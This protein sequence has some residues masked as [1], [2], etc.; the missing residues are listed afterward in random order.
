VIVVTILHRTFLLATLSLFAAIP[1]WCAPTWTQPTPEQLKMTSDPA[2]PD[3]PAVYLFHEETVDDNV[4]F[5]RV[6]A[7]IKILT[8]KGKEDF[9][10]IEIP[11]EGGGS[12]IKAVEGR[13]IHADGTVIPFTGKPYSKE[14]VKSGDVKWMAKVF[15]MPDV[16]VGS[17]IEYR[18]ELQYSDDWYM[19]PRFYLQESAFTHK[20]HYHFVPLNLA[21]TTRILTGKD[22]FGKE[23]VANRLLYYSNLPPGVKVRAGM[24][25]YDLVVENVPA[26]TEEEFSPPLDSYAYQ[27]LF[28]YSQASSGVDFWKEEGKVWSKDVDRFANPSDKI[29]Q[30]VAGIVGVGD[31]DDQKLR[32]IY[33]AVMTVENTRLTRE[34][35]AEENKA[36]GLRVKTAADIWEQK[37]GSD[38][39]ITRLFIAMARA[40]GLKA[41]AMAVPER[42]K[43]LFN[44][45]WL[46]WSQL[47]DEIAIVNAGGKEVFF[48]PG[49]RYCEFGKLHWAHTQMLGIRQSDS[50]PA[51]MTTPGATYQDNQMLRTADL[52]L[53]ADGTLKGTV[54]I[55]MGGAEA[56]RWRQ[57]ALRTDEQEVK[58]DFETLLRGQVPDGVEIKT[59]HFVG[60]TDNTTALLVVMDV[61]GSLGTQTGKRVFLP[62]AFFEAREKPLFAAGKRENPVDMHYPYVAQ[63]K[64]DLVLAP[65]L[66]I[67]S[68]PKG[69]SIPIPQMAIYKADYSNAGS[70]YHQ[71]RVMAIGNTLFKATE[72]PQLREF[73]QKTG[74]QDQEQVVLTRSAEGSAAGD[75][76][77]SE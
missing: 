41:W 44:G 33:A 76:G 37:R 12:D 35:S 54:R 52:T 70:T 17:I 5:H 65:G 4:H 47:E 73:F 71:E 24:D 43:A 28:Y 66:A 21:T 3:A 14:L 16:Q 23:T 19:P 26:L 15:S 11:Y 51:L 38:D 69:T 72:Y 32:K 62:S 68:L 58:K 50:G 9:S 63:D 60:L 55:S 45:G 25:G 20:A 8:E 75:A 49:Q 57:E 40:A 18:W 7:Q 31:S 42:N 74:A 29:R 6:Y 1:A 36:A 34:R 67:E 10:D 61:N 56:L 30:T 27:L 39:E 77:K 53:S 22:A 2:A 46:D 64:V 48:D 59:N 13:T